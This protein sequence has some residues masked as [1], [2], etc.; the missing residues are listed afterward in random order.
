MDKHQLRRRPRHLLLLAAVAGGGGGEEEVVEH[1]GQRAVAATA[2]VH[3]HKDLHLR[4]LDFFGVWTDLAEVIGMA[5]LVNWDQCQ[6][7]QGSF[8]IG[9]GMRAGGDRR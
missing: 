4:I 5:R 8:I 9:V 1:P 6:K 3:R 2:V 7:E